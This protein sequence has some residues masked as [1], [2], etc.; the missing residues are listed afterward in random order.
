MTLDSTDGPAHLALAD[1]LARS[2]ADAARAV[3]EYKAFLRLAGDA[4]PEAAR[5]KKA[6]PTLKKRAG[7]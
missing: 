6:L 3:D 1:L 2:P 4:S 5:V 7:R